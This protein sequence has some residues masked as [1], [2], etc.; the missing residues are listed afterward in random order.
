MSYPDTI[1]KCNKLLGNKN[2]NIY[3]NVNYEPQFIFKS[4]ATV[5]V[6]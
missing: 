1:L 3:I 5:S 4:C 6:T 2:E